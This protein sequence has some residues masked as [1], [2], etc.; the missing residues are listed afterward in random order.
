MLGRN[1]STLS[2]KLGVKRRS[3]EFKNTLFTVQEKRENKKGN[4]KKA[5]A[6]QR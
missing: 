4:E 2:E 1:K 6:E 5:K 3:R